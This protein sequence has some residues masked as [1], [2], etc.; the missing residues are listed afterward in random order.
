MYELP[1][2]I[3]IWGCQ[4]RDGGAARAAGARAT[5]RLSIL[6]AGHQRRNGSAKPALGEGKI[7]QQLLQ[8]LPANHGD[9]SLEEHPEE[10]RHEDAPPA[11]QAGERLDSD[12]SAAA[13][14]K[15]SF[16]IS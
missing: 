13:P 1:A 16:L 8:Q 2:P 11:S 10:S 9:L 15:R 4:G 6:G 5:I 3:S 7:Q 14:F 12:G